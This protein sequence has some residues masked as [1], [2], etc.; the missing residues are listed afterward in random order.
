MRPIKIILNNNLP[1]KTEKSKNMLYGIV[2][3]LAGLKK[4]SIFA[5][6]S[7]KQSF[8]LKK[9]L[10]PIENWKME[11]CE[12]PHFFLLFTEVAKPRSTVFQ[13]GILLH[14]INFLAFKEPIWR[15]SLKNQLE[16]PFWRTRLWKSSIFLMKYKQ[17]FIWESLR[18]ISLLIF[19]WYVE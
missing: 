15:T 19:I 13:K 6:L 11:L 4:G 8:Y 5:S 3:Y 9:K 14:L 18:Q 7:W 1:K 17:G 16:E 10:I 2:F 12:K